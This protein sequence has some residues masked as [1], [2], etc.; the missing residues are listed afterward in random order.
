MQSS[1]DQ[2]SGNEHRRRVGRPGNDRRAWIDDDATP[3]T[4]YGFRRR[5][6]FQS[7]LRY[8]GAYWLADPVIGSHLDRDVPAFVCAGTS[9]SNNATSGWCCERDRIRIEPT[10]SALAS[11]AL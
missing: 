10:H 7:L 9:E 11:T 6:L 8:V 2:L 5:H 3:G 1:E 4:H